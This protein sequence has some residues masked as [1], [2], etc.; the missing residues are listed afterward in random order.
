MIGIDMRQKQIRHIGRIDTNP[1]AFLRKPRIVLVARINSY[2]ML[3]LSDKE[4]IDVIFADTTDTKA[5]FTRGCRVQ[6]VR[7]GTSTGFV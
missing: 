1:A 2:K 5:K 4:N 6:R 7:S 3:F